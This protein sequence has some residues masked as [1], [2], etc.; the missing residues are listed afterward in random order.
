[1]SF[2]LFGISVM[3]FLIL[4]RLWN[5][6][7]FI[8]FAV[9]YDSLC[10]SGFASLK[11]H[12][13]I[14]LCYLWKHTHH[15]MHLSFALRARDQETMYLFF[16]QT[17]EKRYEGWLFQ[18]SRGKKCLFF[19]PEANTILLLILIF[20]GKTLQMT[21]SNFPKAYIRVN[22]TVLTK[23]IEFVKNTILTFF[24]IF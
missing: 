4:Q 17:F 18:H 20:W 9:N 6:G 7:Y 1:M 19:H 3:V 15:W 11:T 14:F 2:N 23:V 12:N 21:L 5:V 24:V 16:D 8:A 10:T 22:T 13:V